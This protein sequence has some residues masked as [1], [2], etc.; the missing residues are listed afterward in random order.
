MG[1]APRENRFSLPTNL[2]FSRQS[3]LPLGMDIQKQPASVEE[4][5]RRSLGFRGFARFAQ[6]FHLALFLGLRCPHVFQSAHVDAPKIG[7][8]W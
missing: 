8:S 5:V 2:Y 7:E 3:L 4:L 6:E 1:Y